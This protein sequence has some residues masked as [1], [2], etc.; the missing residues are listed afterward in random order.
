MLQ[1]KIFPAEVTSG[2]PRVVLV[3]RESVLVEQHRGLVS[4]ETERISLLTECGLLT[5]T[6]NGLSLRRYSEDEAFVG[7]KIE[8]VVLQAVEGRLS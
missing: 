8:G 7:G 2:V 3:G 4:C 1:S 6:G 5:I